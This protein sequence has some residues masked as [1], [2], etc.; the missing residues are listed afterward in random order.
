[1]A[2]KYQSKIARVEQ[3]VTGPTAT[4]VRRA[5]DL[6]RPIRSRSSTIRI[7]G[8]AWLKQQLANPV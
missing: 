8:R 6:R 4:P 3:R 7:A 1:V 5:R 2:V